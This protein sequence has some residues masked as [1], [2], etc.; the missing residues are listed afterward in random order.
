MHLG[1]SESY[2]GQLKKGTRPNPTKDVLEGIASFFG[3]PAAYFLSDAAE[4][5][6]IEA[7]IRYE[8]DLRRFRDGELTEPPVNPS[9][10][11][12]GEMPDSSRPVCERLN[13]LFEHVHSTQEQRPYTEEEVAEA[14]G[15]KTWR[16]RGLR[17]GEITDND[18][19][20]PVLRNLAAF[21]GQKLSYLYADDQDGPDQRDEE[22]LDLVRQ[23][24]NEKRGLL[25]VALRTLESDGGH[26]GFTNRASARA[27]AKLIKTHLE[28]DDDLREN[29]G[30]HPAPGKAG[31]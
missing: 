23:A 10:P 11:H 9:S 3:V 1:V 15:E 7:S 5:A 18:V 27:L 6:R 30:F 25:G 26:A 12:R 21:F 20:V 4:A 24:K 31:Q 2:V 13:W 16:V 29:S 28:L 19:P 14:I 22:L 17:S 8:V